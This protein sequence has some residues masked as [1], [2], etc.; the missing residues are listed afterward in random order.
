M[1]QENDDSKQLKKYIETLQS[2]VS[3][4]QVKLLKSEDEV[5]KLQ[6]L[7]A[8]YCRVSLLKT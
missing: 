8:Q 6:E 2:D 4:L 7:N 3:K 5:R 1:K